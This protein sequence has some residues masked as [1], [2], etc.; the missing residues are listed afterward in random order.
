MN[1]KLLAGMQ[2][3]CGNHGPFNIT[4][5]TVVTMYDDGSDSVSG[6]LVFD[7]NSCC[8]CSVCRKTG[9]VAD[10]FKKPAFPSIL[11]SLV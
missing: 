3:E 9:K 4:V 7:S 5:M 10:F 11:S 8:I 2:C 1:K 6:D